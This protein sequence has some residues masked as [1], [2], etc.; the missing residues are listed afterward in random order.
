M[1]SSAEPPL[2]VKRSL[3]VAANFAN[4]R[5]LASF[6]HGACRDAGVDEAVCIDLELAMVESAN[7]IVEHGYRQGG[8]G[9]IEVNLRFD[10][11]SV[12]LTLS[13]TGTPIPSDNLSDGRPVPPDAV[14]GRG[15][16]IVRS[17]VDEVSYSS[18]AGVNRLRLTKRLPP[19]SV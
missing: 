6:L 1:R 12:V 9:G 3:R 8:G 11:A 16:G 4:V 13:D 15:I 2:P 17:C 14:E 18:E 5:Q 19:A 10:P 7:N